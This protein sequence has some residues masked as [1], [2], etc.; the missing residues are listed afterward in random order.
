MPNS[1]FWYCGYDAE[2][3]RKAMGINHNVLPTIHDSMFQKI[4]PFVLYTHLHT[5]YT[6]LSHKLTLKL[7]TVIT[8]L[9]H[10]YTCPTITTNI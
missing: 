10:F 6:Q 3:M 8:A 7:T 9:Y 2:N 1:M 5:N 4:S